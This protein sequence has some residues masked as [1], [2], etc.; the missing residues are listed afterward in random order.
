VTQ[1]QWETA[2]TYDPGDQLA[3]STTRVAHGIWS[4]GPAQSGNW[5]VKLIEIDIY[6]NEITSGGIDLGEYPSE[7]E[8]KAAAQH[9]ENTGLVLPPS[10][11]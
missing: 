1:L 8:A 7:N 5:S 11:R 3:R 6:G 10:T 4:L 9:Y 2:G